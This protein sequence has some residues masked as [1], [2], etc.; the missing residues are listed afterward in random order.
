[1]S[2]PKYYHLAGNINKYFGDMGLGYLVNAMADDIGMVLTIAGRS[3][4]FYDDSVTACPLK[5]PHDVDWESGTYTGV[6]C[7]IPKVEE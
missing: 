4:R 7:G 1:M 2:Q 5:R 3:V 6:T